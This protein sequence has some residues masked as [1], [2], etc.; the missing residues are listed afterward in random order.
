MSKRRTPPRGSRRLPR[1]SLFYERIVPAI[2]LML[3][4]ALAL[5][6]IAAIAGIA[7]WI[8]F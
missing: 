1:G 4:V 6:L 2:L 5:I 7:G 8:R 3:A